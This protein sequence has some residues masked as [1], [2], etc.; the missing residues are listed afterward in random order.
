MMQKNT[1]L[2]FD[3]P[4]PANTGAVLEAARAAV[5]RTGVGY[6]L[7]ASNTGDTA[8]KVLD[9]FEGT[10]VLLCAITNARGAMMPVANIYGKYTES[11]KIKERYREQGLTSY[12]IS[13]SEETAAA[14]EQRGAVVY[15]VN[16]FLG[17]SGRPRDAGEQTKMKS[18]LDNFLPRHIRPLDVEAGADLSI[19]NIVGMGFRVA[20]GMAALAAW[21]ELVPKGERVLSIAGTGWAGGGADTAVILNADP[22]PRLCRVRDIIAFPREK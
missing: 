15:Y 2:I 3:E 6:A 9:A 17:I 11:R 19:L 5:E 13:I 8:L 18:R 7:V 22:N 1:I 20:V 14:L 4:G 16:D 12:P 21:N 10:G